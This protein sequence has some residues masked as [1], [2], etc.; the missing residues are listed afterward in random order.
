[1]TINVFGLKSG[2]RLQRKDIFFQHSTSEQFTGEY[3]V[4]GKKIYCRYITATTKN[5]ENTVNSWGIKRII[6]V[7]GFVYSQY[8]QYWPI[9]SYHQEQNYATSYFLENDR[10][11]LR[12]WFGNYFPEGT[13]IELWVKYTKTTD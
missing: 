6:D 4:D 8:G 5:V 2:N 9:P 7:K 11:T 3:F 13:A 12:L 10:K 1:M